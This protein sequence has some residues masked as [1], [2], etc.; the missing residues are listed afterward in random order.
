MYVCRPLKEQMHAET[1]AHTQPQQRPLKLVATQ[2]IPYLQKTHK[3]IE[4]FW[5]PH[6]ILWPPVGTVTSLTLPL[7][8]SLFLSQSNFS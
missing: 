2:S 8:L 6:T 1:Y 5:S 7:T 4:S 3:A